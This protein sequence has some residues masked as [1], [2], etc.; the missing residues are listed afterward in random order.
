MKT[1]ASPIS[2][3]RLGALT[4]VWA[5]LGGGALVFSACY[6]RNCEGAQLQYGTDAGQGELLDENTWESSPVAGNWLP[7]FRQHSIVMTIPFGGRTPFD[8]HAYVSAQP[9]PQT[10][11]WTTGSGNLVEQ[12]WNTNQVIVIND[13]CS[14]YYIRVVAFAPPFGVADGGANPATRMA[15]EVIDAASDAA[16][17]P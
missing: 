16:I 8:A 2:W 7:F 1:N 17:V 5:V 14:D 10:G 12:I 11:Q 9:V 13:T 15:A 4:A 3:R 6:G